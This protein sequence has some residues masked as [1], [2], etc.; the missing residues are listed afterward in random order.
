MQNLIKA[1]IYGAVIGDALG[2]PFE[3]TEREKLIENPVKDM[4]GYGTYYK[5]IGTWSDDSGLIL[6]TLD[7]L[8]T[9]FNIKDVAWNFIEW[10]SDNKYMQKNVFDIGR[11]TAGSIYELIKSINNDILEF[12]TSVNDN[13]NG[14]L[15]RIIPAALYIYYTENIC[16]YSDINSFNKDNFIKRRDF[17]YS[18]S[19]LTHGNIISKIACHIYVEMS[20]F[21]LSGYGKHD[22]YKKTCK[23]FHENWNDDYIPFKKVLNGKL[24][25]KS[26]KNIKSDGFVINTLEAAIWCLLKNNSYKST[27]LSSV[28]L[29]EDTDTTACVAG[30]LAGILYGIGFK[31]IP[32]KWIQNIYKNEIIINIIDKF[33]KNNI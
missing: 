5:P 12:G 26:S 14:S 20:L 11:T 13:G 6:A 21:L 1:A 18:L 16:E 4:V 19:A 27:V 23:I 33:K 28:N 8:N 24:F 17:V 32:E 10:E 22:A 3:F 15:M 2:V 9:P 25:F 7:G 30:G 31:G 29:G